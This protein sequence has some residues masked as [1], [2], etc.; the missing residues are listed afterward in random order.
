LGLAYVYCQARLLQANKGIPA[1]RHAS[2]AL[3][4]VATDITEGVGLLCVAALVWPK[5]ATSGV[6]L[7]VLLVARFLAWR[8]Y[9]RSLSGAGVPVGTTAV[10]DEIDDRFVRLGHFV[11]AILGLAAGGAEFPLFVALAGGIAA[12]SGAA[13]KYTLVRRAAFTQGFALPRTPMRGQ[14]GAGPGARPGWN[15]ARPQ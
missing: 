6:G 1:W 10:F 5:L 9:R 8:H 15:R 3:M 4:I 2:C 14:G 13:F 7:A 12:A 11:P